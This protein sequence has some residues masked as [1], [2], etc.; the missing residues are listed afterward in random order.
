MRPDSLKRPPFASGLDQARAIVRRAGPESH[1]PPSTAVRRLLAYA[2]EKAVKADPLAADWR[3]AQFRRQYPDATSDF[4]CEALIK[5]KCQHTALIGGVSAAPGVIPGI[6]TLVSLTLGAM[7]DIG[8]TVKAQ[9]ELVLEIAAVYRYPMDA[10]Q[11][12]EVVL[13][14]TGLGTGAQQLAGKA[15]QR[16]AERYAQQGIARALP[17]IGI[18]AA[19]GTNVLATYIIGRRAQAYFSRGPESIGD[20]KASLR[21]V[22]GVDE[23]KIA[24]WL[25]ETRTGLV[26]AVAN[27]GGAVHRGLRNTAGRLFGRRQRPADPDPALPLPADDGG[28]PQQDRP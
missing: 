18:A 14:V 17:V 6:G 4:L 12:R 19:A 10:V 28:P 1:R 26:D 24:A 2:A 16:V 9:A 13:L 23:R 11:R 25:A 7:V 22:S 20:W 3:T 5:A 21:A 15:G 8:S 27:A